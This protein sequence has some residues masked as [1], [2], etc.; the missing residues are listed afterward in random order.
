MSMQPYRWYDSN[1]LAAYHRARGV[2]GASRPER[3]R[4]FEASF[5]VLRTRR[6]FEV[7][8]FDAL[9]DAATFAA[10]RDV[11]A[12]LPAAVI[13][14]HEATRFGRFVVHNQ[15]YFDRLHAQLVPLVSTAARE[16][17]E[18]SYNF[19]SLYGPKGSCGPHMDAPTAK[20]TL[21]VCINQNAPWPIFFSQ[22]VEWP[23]RDDWPGEQWEDA[24]KHSPALTFTPRILEPNQ[25]VLFS[26]SGQWHYRDPIPPAPG[27]RFCDLLFFHFIPV[28]TRPLVYPKQWP[29]HF[30]LPELEQAVTSP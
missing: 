21:D 27:R 28:G 15:E 24:I 3:R 14:P 29:Q 16:P 4:Q 19:L 9:F 23:D 1:W 20:Y 8:Q 10:I 25:A 12:H 2:L 7:V 17:V 13:E 26:G 30:G 11:I 22:V 6:D 5:D 18:P